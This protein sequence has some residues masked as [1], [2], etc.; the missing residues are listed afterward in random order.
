MFARIKNSISEYYSQ[1]DIVE[2]SLDTVLSGYRYY[3]AVSA[4]GLVLFATP[5]VA[6]LMWLTVPAIKTF[7]LIDSQEEDKIKKQASCLKY[8]VLAGGFYTFEKIASS[9]LSYIPAFSYLKMS[10]AATLIYNDFQLSDNIFDIVQDKYNN[11]EHREKIN[12]ILGELSSR[13]R[14]D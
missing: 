3:I 2:S 9:A 7:S 1:Q 5:T 4:V 10:L 8:W 13:L 12:L 11:W 6:D 14:L